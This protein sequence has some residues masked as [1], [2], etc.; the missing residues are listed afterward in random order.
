MC[1]GHLVNHFCILH[2]PEM[3]KSKGCLIIKVVVN[4]VFLVNLYLH[5]PLFKSW[6]CV[7]GV[8]RALGVRSE[9]MDNVTGTMGAVLIGNH[10]ISD[11]LDE[12]NGICNG[13]ACL[14]VN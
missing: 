12:L 11:A 1:L 7:V 13:S 6:L 8:P 10:N 3:L 14:S 5:W 4:H 9:R 2:N